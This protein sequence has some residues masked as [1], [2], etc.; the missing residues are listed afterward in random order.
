MGGGYGGGG[1][2]GLLLRKML[3]SP[4]PSVLSYLARLWSRIP[5]EN[6]EVQGG[7]ATV[8]RCSELNHMCGVGR[9]GGGEQKS[10]CWWRGCGC[11]RGGGVKVVGGGGPGFLVV[12][13]GGGKS[14][15]VGGGGP[16]LLVLRNAEA[17]PVAKAQVC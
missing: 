16:G 12:S 4:L 5:T 10:Y 13:G 11:V 1:G 7:E 15:I 9:G 8:E 6:V 14:R 2:G 17:L 3:C